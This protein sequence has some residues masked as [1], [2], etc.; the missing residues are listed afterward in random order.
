MRAVTL[1]GLLLAL[2]CLQGMEAQVIVLSNLRG[3]ALLSSNIQ[4]WDV[5]RLIRARNPGASFTTTER[6]NTT[7]GTLRSITYNPLFQ[8]DNLN[9]K[10]NANS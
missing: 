2:L 8:V 10:K 7:W 5:D 3:N 6:P 1:L 9:T 4:V